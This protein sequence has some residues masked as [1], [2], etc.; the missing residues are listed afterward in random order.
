ME[1]LKDNVEYDYEI[2]AHTGTI[3]HSDRDIEGNSIPAQSSADIGAD[4]AKEI[5][6]DHAGV[7]GPRPPLC[8]PIWTMRTGR[9]GVTM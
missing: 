1:F 2:D 3:L 4:R 7:S 8:G 6:L 9:R 5:A